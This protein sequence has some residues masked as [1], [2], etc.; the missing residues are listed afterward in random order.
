MER[1]WAWG[2]FMNQVEFDLQVAELLVATGLIT[3][4]DCDRAHAALR[5]GPGLREYLI[6]SGSTN[7]ILWTAAGQVVQLVRQGKLPKEEARAV[8]NLV[9]STGMPLDESLAKMGY[10]PAPSNPWEDKLR[11]LTESGKYKAV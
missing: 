9:G 1:T 5:G 3:S 2:C 7:D 11:E 10:A 8:L 4:Y 6:D